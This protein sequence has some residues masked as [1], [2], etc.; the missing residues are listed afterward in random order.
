M[1]ADDACG[2][3][4]LLAQANHPQ[5]DSLRPLRADERTDEYSSVPFRDYRTGSF[6]RVAGA[7][8]DA[9]QVAD[10]DRRRQ[11]DHSRGC[12]DA[13]RPAAVQARLRSLRHDA[14]PER[15]YV[16]IGNVD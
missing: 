12:A 1:D 13:S 7:A 8:L 6:D 14:R 16:G 15:G 2:A 11:R 5:R 4:A 3:V 10:A 9:I